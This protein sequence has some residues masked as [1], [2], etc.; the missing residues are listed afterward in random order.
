MNRAWA[1]AGIALLALAAPAR[2]QT[3][4]FTPDPVD[5]AAARKEGAVTWY[6]STPVGTAQKIANL[7]QAETGIKV[8]LFVDTPWHT[9]QPFAEPFDIEAPAEAILAQ[10]EAICRSRPGFVSR[11]EW[12]RAVAA[13]MASA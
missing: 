9:P 4:A 8:E 5:L 2:A 10:T 6:T 12:R 1:I 13:R 11:A 3:A 7:F